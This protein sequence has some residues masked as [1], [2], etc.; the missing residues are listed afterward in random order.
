MEKTQPIVFKK[1]FAPDQFTKDVIEQLFAYESQE[2][3]TSN[4]TD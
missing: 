2:N 1:I 3:K 4:F